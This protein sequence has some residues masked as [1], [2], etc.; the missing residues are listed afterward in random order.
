MD[1]RP[2]TLLTGF[3][4]SGKTTLLNALL[5]HPQLSRTAVVI[6]EFGETGIDHLLVERGVDEVLLLDGGCICCSVTTTLADTLTELLGKEARGEVPPFVRVIVETSGLAEPEPIVRQLWVD[7]F[8]RERFALDAIV[9]VVSAVEAPEQLPRFPEASRQTAA[10]DRIVLTKTD[11]ADPVSLAAVNRAL[12][13]VNTTAPRITAAMARA[14]PNAIIG[15]GPPGIRPAGDMDAH[16]HH[17]HAERFV[18]VAFTVTQPVTWEALSAWTEEL[19]RVCGTG[20]LR[21][22]GVVE[23]VGEPA[24]VVVQ[25]IGQVFHPPVR[26]HERPAADFRTRIVVIGEGVERGRVERTIAVLS[27]A[28][29]ITRG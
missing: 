4:G 25:G 13:A 21:C 24:P 3:L 28:A 10:A 22:K 7:S 6:N 2:V 15:I 20:L 18:S 16:A 12:D 14:D 5:K 17:H 29:A 11:L 26:L 1:K 27:P 23:V 19:R 8:M 9:T